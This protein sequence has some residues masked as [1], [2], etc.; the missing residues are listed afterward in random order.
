MVSCTNLLGL[1][2]LLNSTVHA[3][4]KNGDFLILL[5]SQA[6]HVGGSVVQLDQ[7]VVD[8]ELLSLHNFL[9]LVYEAM[10]LGARL[11]LNESSSSCNCRLNLDMIVEVSELLERAASSARSLA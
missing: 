1:V 11:A 5:L 6:I 3:L 4:L 9:P 8:L 7:E 10:R 2:K